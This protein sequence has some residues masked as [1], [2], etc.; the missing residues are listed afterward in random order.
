MFERAVSFWKRLLGRASRSSASQGGQALEERR[1][2]LRYPADLETTYQVPDGPDARRFSARVRDISLGGVSLAVDRPFEP[3]GLLSVELPG[4]T[5]HARCTAL[6]CVVHVT[7]SAPGE[8]TIGCTFSRELSEDDLEAFGVRRERHAPP[9]QRKWVRFPCEVT[10]LYQIITALQPEAKPSR[11]LNLAATGVG[12]EVAEAVENGTLLSVELHAAHGPC[13]RTMLACV[14]HVA[15]QGEGK[16]ALGCN[17]IR[18]LS[19]EEL[20]A[21]Q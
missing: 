3:G 16:W 13:K 20:K 1:V 14:V 17:F 12:L 11:V 18:S 5:E 9:D 6:A 7:A 15:Q 21:L 8:W 10:A 2:W 19:E 4:A